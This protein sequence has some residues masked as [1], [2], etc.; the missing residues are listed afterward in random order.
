[1]KKRITLLQ[2]RNDL[3]MLML[4]PAYFKSPPDMATISAWNA[5]ITD[6][7]NE[8]DRHVSAVVDS[9]EAATYFTL[10]LPDGLVM[11]ERLQHSTEYVEIFSHADYAAEWQSIPGRSQKLAVGTYD[12]A[13]SQ[14]LIGNDQISSI[15][16]PDGLAVRGYEHAWRQGA[17][18]D[19]TTDTPAVPMDWNDRISSL[20][21]Y[22]SDEAPPRT[23]YVVAL[24]YTWSLPALLLEAGDYPDLSAN[25]LGLSKLSTLLIPQGM[26]VRIWDQA[27]F[28]GMS[29]RF[30]SDVLE[31]P[32]EW[33]NR[34]ASLKVAAA[35]A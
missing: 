7:L 12:D 32:V 35:D 5:A 33:N 23:D 4:H 16:V 8:L 2:I 13:K 29:S 1:M 9:V 6:D 17:F 19:F 21:V 10:T 18:I 14:I 3:E 22:R 27:N 26:S 28:Q 34:A 24:D 20:V 11:P 25:S 30:F 15:K 31:L